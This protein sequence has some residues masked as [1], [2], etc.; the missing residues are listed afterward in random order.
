MNC[1]LY[2][3]GFEPRC[4]CPC[5]RLSVMRI[6]FISEGKC[7][8]INLSLT[9]RDKKTKRK[10]KMKRKWRVTHIISYTHSHILTLTHKSDFGEMGKNNSNLFEHRRC[11]DRVS[12]MA[13]HLRLVLCGSSIPFR[14]FRRER[15]LMFIATMV[16]NSSSNNNNK[17]IRNVLDFGGPRFAYR[18]ECVYISLTLCCRHSR[19]S[20]NI[21][22]LIFFLCV[23][24][25]LFLLLCSFSVRKLMSRL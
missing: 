4:P 6:L 21:N 16:D 23:F 5:R 20:D 15:N 11:S 17:I 24:G 2:D 3:G 10:N 25:L 19:C 18:G 12:V 14:Y 8:A 9:T 13:I 22:S 7:C 1:Y